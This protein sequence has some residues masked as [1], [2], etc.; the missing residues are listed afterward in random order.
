MG[1]QLW[2]EL[3]KETE[4][5]FNVLL[6]KGGGRAREKEESGVRL[7][8]RKQKQ[9]AQC[10]RRQRRVWGVTTLCA[11]LG[12]RMFPSQKMDSLTGRL[13]WGSPHPE[14]LGGIGWFGDGSNRTQS[15]TACI[16]MEVSIQ[17]TARFLASVHKAQKRMISLTGDKLDLREECF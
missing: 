17:E 14:R 13:A 3:T 5:I 16:F 12:R 8:L 7:Q 15:F 6:V 11:V 10:G 9:E 4:I 1:W 2:I